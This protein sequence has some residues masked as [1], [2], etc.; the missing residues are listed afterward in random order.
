MLLL[1]RETLLLRKLFANGV[2]GLTNRLKNNK[3]NIVIT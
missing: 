1:R 3:S 2:E